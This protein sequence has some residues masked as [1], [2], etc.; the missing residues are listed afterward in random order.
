MNGRQILEQREEKDLAPYAAKAGRSLGR[1]HPEPEHAYRTAFQRDRDRVIHSS[2]FRRLKYKTQVYFEGE[3]DY[4]RTR[5]T[6]TFEASQISRTIARVLGLNEDLCE[7]LALAHDLG[8]PP[9]GH[10]GEAALAECMKNHGGFEHN[11]Q[12]LRIVEILENRYPDFPGLNL[13]WEARESI[14]KHSVKPK[15]PVEPEYK[16]EWSPLLECETVDLSDYIAYVAHDVD[17]AVKA[18]LLTLEQLEQIELWRSA[19]KEVL[20]K[21]PK[22]R[23]ELMV[24]QVVRWLI[25]RMVTDLLEH[26]DQA[27][28]R[29]GIKTLDDV[30]QPRDPIAGFS[31]ELKVRVD[32]LYRFLY[33]NVYQ[34]WQVERMHEKAK[35]FVRDLFTAYTT[36]PKMLPPQ[37]Q[38]SA[39]ANGVERA[40][41]DY[42]A[43][44]TDRYAQDEHKKLFSPFEPLL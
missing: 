18:G 35:R 41:C 34:H 19:Q 30:R 17:D 31:P 15:Y 2:A 23:G 33:K 11:L 7:V 36:H 26:T 28:A 43:G 3:R 1:K 13:T 9:F 39:R 40:V 25:E 14:R 4:F 10:T 42:I 24:R 32:E 27:I 8:H 22:L 29:A 21:H 12:S 37:F 6:H 38:E 20:K 16:P 5:I 44:M